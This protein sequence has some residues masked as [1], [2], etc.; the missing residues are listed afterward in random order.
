MKRKATSTVPDVSKKRPRT[1]FQPLSH[2]HNYCTS[3]SKVIP[4]MKKSLEDKRKKIKSLSKKRLH[5]E[6][7]I[8][9]LLKR[10][11][12]LKH[13][14]K[15]QGENLMSNFGHKELFINQQKNAQKSKASWYSD[16]VKKFAVSLHFYS[17][18][19]YRFVRKSLHL[20]CPATIRSWAAAIDC[21]PGFLTNVIDELKNSLNENE[22]DCVVLVDEMSIKKEVLWDRKNKKFAGN[23][24]YG[25]IL[26][27][28]QD[29][30]ESNDLVFMAVGLKEPWLH[31][32]AYF[33]V[34]RVNGKMQVP[35]IKEAINFLTEAGL[36]VQ[37]VIFDDCAK[38]LTTGRCLGCSINKFDGS[39]NHPSRPNK[40]LYVILDVCHMLKL[41]RNS[42][43]DLKVFYTDAGAKMCWNYITELYNVQ[44][45]DV[46]H[47]GN[48][49]KTKHIKWHNQ[50]MKV[51]I[52]AQTLSNSVAAGLMY[53]KVVN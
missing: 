22:K 53:L 21:E 25:A 48:K 27:E 28:E 30:I 49:L 41:A 10:L 12:D 33:L 19:A 14:S 50:K 51:A 31:P 40:T 7:T 26:A 5:R 3:P 8:K 9:G 44:K 42:L 16:A 29:S 17:P 6:K 32:I 13:L 11:Q 4:K 43:G 2:D 52:A 46:L 39:F 38:N 35:L 37:A 36:D 1:N 34:D 23:T 15:E 18:E 47:L 45:T 20:P 24:D